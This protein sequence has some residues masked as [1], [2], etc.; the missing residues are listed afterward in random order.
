MSH[1]ATGE[2]ELADTICIRVLD[3]TFSLHL[4]WS[5][6]IVRSRYEFYDDDDEGMPPSSWLEGSDKHG[7][8]F[9]LDDFGIL[10]L[11]DLKS[12]QCFFQSSS[13]Q[14]KGEYGTSGAMD[15]WRASDI[16]IFHLE[17]D[18]FTLGAGL[19]PVCG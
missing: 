14:R 18:L 2:D 15:L 1:Y 3:P 13:V 4:L 8:V 11:L 5:F 12:G 7:V 10:S 16:S 9:H 17:E 19:G 6:T